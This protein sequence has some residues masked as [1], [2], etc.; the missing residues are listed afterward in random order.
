MSVDA[1]DF[2]PESEIYESELQDHQ[3]KAL[4][5]AGKSILLESIAVSRDFCK[6]M[7]GFSIGAVP[8]YLSLISLFLHEQEH[9]T[10]GDR[11]WLGSPVLAFVCASVAF[12]SGYMPSRGQLSLLTVEGIENNRQSAITRRI[13]AGIGGFVIFNL[14]LALATYAMIWVFPK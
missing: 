12:V 7:I 9:F 14:G 2:L 11:M 8:I 5:E 6:F 10:R 13:V 3:D 1:D 4:I